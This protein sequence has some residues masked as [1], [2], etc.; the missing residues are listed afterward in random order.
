MTR[1]IGFFDSP[2]AVRRAIEA[3]ATT[4]W[5]A[6]TLCSPVY[7]EELLQ[8]V[9]ATRSPVPLWTLIGG[10]AGTLSGLLLTIGTV[11]Q[12]PGLIVSGKPLLAVPAFLVIVFE[13]AILGASIGAVA[14]FFLAARHARQ[15]AGG[16]CDRGTSDDR[17]AVLFESP[18]G[19]SDAGTLLASATAIEWRVL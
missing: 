2:E 7:D 1:A 16:A 9:G 10:G 13:L 12:W 5:R 18:D 14:A 3:S 4:S 19:V 8:L 15:A 17:F 11:R 6:V